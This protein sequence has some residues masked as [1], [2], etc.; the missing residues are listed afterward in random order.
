MQ[1]SQL[2]Q[3]PFDNMAKNVLLA[4]D[5]LSANAFGFLLLWMLFCFGE[6]LD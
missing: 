2:A 4:D 3:T 5:G 1:A 6:G